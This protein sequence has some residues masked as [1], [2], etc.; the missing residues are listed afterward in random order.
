MGYYRLKDQMLRIE[1]FD[2]GMTSL[3]GI[4]YALRLGHV[5]EDGTV[6]FDRFGLRDAGVFTRDRI[7]EIKDHEIYEPMPIPDTAN[8]MVAW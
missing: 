6:A 8:H 7:Y 5:R 3:R 2:R 1:I 4:L